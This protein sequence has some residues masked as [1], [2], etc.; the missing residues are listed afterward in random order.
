MIP[1]FQPQDKIFHVQKES[2][3]WAEK[4]DISYV[5]D[6]ND[7][8][9]KEG[10]S[11]ILL[12]QEALQ[13]AKISDIA[14]RIVS[15][16]NKKFIMIAGPSSSGKTSFSHRLSIQLTAHGMK[17][18]PI[19]VD[20]YFKNRED[21]PF[22]EFGEKIMNVSK[23]SMWSSSIKTCWRFLMESVWNSRYLILRQD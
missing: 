21:T 6:L 19:G 1:P 15:E 17:P 18:H 5:G 16:G 4:M 8:I 11:N 12:V 7:R 3:E 23:Q 14:Q 2:Q 20:N 13:E 22:D 10:I 9:T